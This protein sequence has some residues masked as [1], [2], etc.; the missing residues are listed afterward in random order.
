MP[1]GDAGGH[2]FEFVLAADDKFLLRLANGDPRMLDIVLG[3]L[4]RYD[5]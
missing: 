1:D 5:P 2:A 3:I 4:L